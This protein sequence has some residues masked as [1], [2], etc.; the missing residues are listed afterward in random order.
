[1]SRE[2]QR[3]ASSA[4][5]H[6]VLIFLGIL[7]AG[8]AAEE[9]PVL[10]KPPALEKGDLIALV[11]PA[12]PLPAAQARAAVEQLRKRGYTAKVFDDPPRGYLAGTDAAR[13][14]ALNQA[15]RDPDVKAIICLRGGYGS[16]R[17]LDQIDYE[18]LRKTPKILVGYSDITA[19]LLAVERHSG[20]VTFLGPM[21]KE[22]SAARGLTPYAEKYYWAAL[23]P[24]PTSGPLLLDWGGQRPSGLKAPVAVVGGSAEGVLVGGNL[25]VI[26][27]TLGTPYEIDA[28]GSILFIEEV[29]EKPFRIDRLLNQL[30]LAGKLRE[31]RGILLGAFPA[32][33]S[34]D[35][36]GDLS[37]TEVFADYFVPLG[38]P[39]LA[40]FP[41][42]HIA[43]QALL[44][45]GA[46]VRLDATSRKLSILESPVDLS[47]SAGAGSSAAEG[48]DGSH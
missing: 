34:R 27:S 35:P 22:W 24:S 29:A 37:L 15:V 20:I 2:G 46:R 39:V 45:I 9:L 23:A 32:C 21:G 33:D 40:D 11:A 43:D 5:H 25:S 42:G 4:L 26:C 13:A 41:A 1:M 19:L 3:A 44:P 17:I 30:R 28:R 6:G 36:E 10:T 47:R 48:K 14:A 38:V 8:L 31:A 12:S 7:P 16:P 18:A